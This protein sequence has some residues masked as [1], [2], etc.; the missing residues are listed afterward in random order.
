MGNGGRR[1]KTWFTVLF[2]SSGGKM[3]N[4]QKSNSQLPIAVKVGF[5]RHFFFLRLHSEKRKHSHP[6][7]TTRLNFLLLGLHSRIKEK[8]S[9]QYN[10]MILE[11]EY[12][13]L[14]TLQRLGSARTLLGFLRSM[15]QLDRPEAVTKYKLVI[16]IK[17]I[18]ILIF[19][20][21]SLKSM[22]AD[23]SN[24][25]ASPLVASCGE[26]SPSLW[27]RCDKIKSPH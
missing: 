27:I 17:G 20:E 10:Y 18:M 5:L 19:W 4:T 2:Y 11:L 12:F 3:V 14:K 26:I 1:G 16:P 15:L 21:K 25:L 7:M 24:H 8:Y 23:Y 9:T 6:L 22:E 13:F